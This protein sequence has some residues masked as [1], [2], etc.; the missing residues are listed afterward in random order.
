MKELL[1]IPLMLA[2]ALFGYSIMRKL[3]QWIEHVI[4]SKE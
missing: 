4:E 2:L 1:L 3:D